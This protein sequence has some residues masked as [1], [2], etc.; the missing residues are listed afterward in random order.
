RLTAGQELGAA[1]GVGAVGQRRDGLLQVGG[2]QVIEPRRL[3]ALPAGDA[4]D[5]VA[6]SIASNRR[7]GV[8]GG[9]LSSTPSGRSA[10]LT[11]LKITA[12]G[13]IAPPSPMPLMPN[14]V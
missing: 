11:A 8:S 7:R 1:L 3:H 9:S 10:S 13:A 4:L 12:G 6:R 14:C 2:P 5:A